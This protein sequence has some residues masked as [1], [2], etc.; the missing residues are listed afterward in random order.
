MLNSYA[1]PSAA[2]RRLTEGD[3]RTLIGIKH[4]LVFLAFSFPVIAL[5][6][7]LKIPAWYA[8][9]ADYWVDSFTHC[10]FNGIFTPYDQPSISL[11]AISGF[12]YI[13]VSWGKMAFSTA[14]F[15]DIVWDIAVGRAGQALLAFITFRVSSQYLAMAMREAPVSYNTFESLAFV[16]PSLIRT[17][18]LAGDLLT[19]RGWRA[20]LIIIWIVLSSLFVLSFSTLVTAMSGYSSNVYAV[21]PDYEGRSVVWTNFQVVQFSIN[22]AWRIGEPEPVVITMGDTCV[23]QGFLDDDDDDD[24]DSGNYHDSVHSRR[25]D[26]DDDDDDNDG[27]GQGIPWEYVPFNCTVFWRTV[28]CK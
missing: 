28:Q 2:E 1:A 21:M 20:R 17:G 23:H 12:F 13:S 5:A 26:N 19:N 3:S 7:V 25:D 10:N 18:R 11:W 27:D 6:L 8:F 24:D 16:P 14:K 4:V 22:D 15:I 9:H